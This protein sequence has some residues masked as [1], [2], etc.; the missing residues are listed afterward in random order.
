MLAP[1]PNMGTNVNDVSL[2]P[3]NLSLCLKEAG[4]SIE[5]VN[6]GE[7]GVH[8]LDLDLSTSV[9]EEMY[10]LDFALQEYELPAALR[11]KLLDAWQ[12]GFSNASIDSVEMIEPTEMLPAAS[13]ISV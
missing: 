11:G 6:G 1:H 2:G 9:L 7:Q 10:D 12:R 5:A 4:K 3:I 8:D 13:A